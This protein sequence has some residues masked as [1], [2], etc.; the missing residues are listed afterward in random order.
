M[1][2]HRPGRLPEATANV[3]IVYT[4]EQG[5]RV[6]ELVR[7]MDRAEHQGVGA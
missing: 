5:T 2:G 4:I 3:R 6:A 1:C 7:E